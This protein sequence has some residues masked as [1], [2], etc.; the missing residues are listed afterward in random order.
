MSAFRGHATGAA[1]AGPAGQ[2]Y[3]RCKEFSP[4]GARVAGDGYK[5]IC[6]PDVVNRDDTRNVAKALDFM[7]K[8]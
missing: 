7:E 5:I 2:P 3:M 6:N 1:Y 8:K 4:S